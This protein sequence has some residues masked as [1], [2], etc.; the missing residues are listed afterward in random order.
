MEEIWGRAEATVR[1]VQEALNARGGK[2]R[3][4][5]TLL[6]VM[7]RL[8][9]QGP[10]RPPPCRA[11]RRLRRRRWRART[12]CRRA[13]R[14]RSRRW[15]RTSVTLRSRTS[16]ATSARS[17]RSGWRRSA[18]WPAVTDLRR[19]EF[20]VAAFGATAFL[21]ALM[22][23][24]TRCASTATCSRRA[25]GAAARR[26]PRARRAADRAGALRPVRARSRDRLDLA[27]RGGAPPGRGAGCR[28]STSARS[29]DGGSR[30]WP[31][32]GRWRSAPGCCGRGCSSPRGRWSGSARTSWPPSSRTRATTRRG[33]TRC[34]S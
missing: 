30:S 12:T 3:A 9:A 17:T 29:R 21:L 14:P 20:A 22:F 31:A 26:V 18:A 27:W 16:R 11:A 4:Y 25:A 32:L 5:T 10:A 2:I 19:A 28:C 7:T 8:D 6:T 23:V 33:A 1:D 24:S 13:P 34:G 15:S